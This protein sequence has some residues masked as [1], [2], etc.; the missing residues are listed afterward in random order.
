MEMVLR[1]EFSEEKWPFLCKN[2]PIKSKERNPHASTD[3]IHIPNV[4]LI[5]AG[6]GH[7]NFCNKKFL[8]NARA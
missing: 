1:E 6:N 2:I 8:N 7:K 4:I 3:P 5:K